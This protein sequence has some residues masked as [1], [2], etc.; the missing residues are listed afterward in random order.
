MSFGGNR[1]RA[2]A[3]VVSV[4]VA[5]A[6]AALV[7]PAAAAAD[8]PQ[9]QADQYYAALAERAA[10]TTPTDAQLQA[11]VEA[12]LAGEASAYASADDP[13]RFVDGNLVSDVVFFQGDAWTAT[14]LQTFL[15]TK[16]ASCTG[17]S[18]LKS[19]TMDTPTKA[20]D[21]ACSA[22][23]GRTGATAAQIFAEVGLACGINPVVLVSLVQKEQGL[24]TT[25]APTQWM[26]D[27]ATGWLCPDTEAG[28]N[29]TPDATGF[30]NQVYGAAWQFKQYGIDPSFNW[31]PVGTVSPVRYNLDATCGSKQVA[32]QDKATAALYYYTPYT[33]DAASLASY[34][35][36]GDDCSAYGIRNFWM[37]FNAWYGDS[38]AGSVPAASR[39]SGA[40]RFTTSAAISAAA[41]PNP[42]A[43][44]PAVYVA[45][46]LAFP[47][48]LG[49]APAAVKL[50]GPMLLVLQYGVPAPIMTELQRLKPKKIYIAGGVN[51][52][53][54][55]AVA[56][57][58]TVAPVDRIGGGDRFETSRLIAANAFSAP[59]ATAYLASGLNFPDA[60]SAGAAAGAKGSPVILVNGGLTAADPETVA[61]LTALGVT[62]V[63]IVGGAS[64]ISTQY[65]ASIQSKGFAVTRLSGSDRFQ[66][67]FAVSQDAFPGTTPA[68]FIASGT[69]F[70]DAL[71]GAAY[72]GKIG[73]PLLVSRAGCIEATGAEIALR[74]SAINLVGGSNA[75]ADQVGMLSVCQ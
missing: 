67:S 16:G 65:A 56:Q 6:G 19:F 52:V 39:I 50:G 20:A 51:S 74:S 17:S 68:T 35:G 21:A 54:P 24:V 64:S 23:A 10:G 47:D 49:A 15:T 61:Q 25:S 14:Q 45:N 5:I 18:C 57:L 69:Q 44:V 3:I 70:P 43:G 62:N 33:P 7:V 2:R 11:N 38:T 40:D 32:I 71:S 22:Y 72:A 60:L 27:H 73:S 1:A 26:Y 4:V 9:G 29:S 12:G 36:E 63:K 34:P 37:L 41:Y 55:D 58:Q 48:A 46:G 53:G 30:F 13:S 75:L 42:G 28:C 59:V 31:F 8:D 66:T